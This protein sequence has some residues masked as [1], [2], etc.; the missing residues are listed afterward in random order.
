[1]KRKRPTYLVKLSLYCFGLLFLSVCLGK[2]LQWWC[3]ND[4]K[5][6]VRFPII[7]PLIQFSHILDGP[8]IRVSAFDKVVQGRQQHHRAVDENVPVHRRRIWIL[9]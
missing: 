2:L 8:V 4:S 5:A 1:M 9:V 3:G 7:L 6:P